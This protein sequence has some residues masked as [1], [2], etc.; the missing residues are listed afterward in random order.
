ML[1]RWQR[2]GE[3]PKSCASSASLFAFI[4]G[5]PWAW[6][7]W[8]PVL[9]ALYIAHGSTRGSRENGCDLGGRPHGPDRLTGK[10]KLANGN[11]NAV[12]PGDRQTIP[13]PRLE[14]QE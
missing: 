2:S 4:C 13:A 11:R 8:S 6:I 12:D 7:D 1:R 14:D 9:T 5:P 3:L 10:Y